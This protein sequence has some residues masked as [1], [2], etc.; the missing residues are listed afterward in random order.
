MEADADWDT[1]EES[2][3]GMNSDA[4]TNLMHMF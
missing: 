3:M 4:H 2:N 1:D